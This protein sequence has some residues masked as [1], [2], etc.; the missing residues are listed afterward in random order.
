MKANN[1]LVTFTFFA[2]VSTICFADVDG[3]VEMTKHA[4]DIALPSIEEAFVTS[5]RSSLDRV[6]ISR[7]RDC[8]DSVY[9]VFEAKQAYR[10]FGSHWIVSRNK[11]SG[12]IDI[13]DGI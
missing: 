1:R 10:N 13:Q 12:K 7:G 8:G 2:V 9:F 3:C 5:G 4:S 11:K 6:D